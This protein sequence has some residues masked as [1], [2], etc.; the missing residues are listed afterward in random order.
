MITYRIF[1]FL[2]LIGYSYCSIST[3]DVKMKIIG[4][5]L[6]IANALMFWR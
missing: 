2:M 1:Y 6:I 5:S 4:V 3:P